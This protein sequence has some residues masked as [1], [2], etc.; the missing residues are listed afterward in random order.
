MAL[1]WKNYHSTTPLSGFNGYVK[2]ISLK[3][4]TQIETTSII[5]PSELN[6][7]QVEVKSNNSSNTFYNVTGITLTNY[8]N[9]FI[10]SENAIIQDGNGFYTGLQFNST[11]SIKS[12]TG[13]IN[14]IIST[15]NETH[16]Y[17]QCGPIVPHA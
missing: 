13:T 1:I 7:K 3:N 11:F 6:L 16:Y 4:N 9:I 10:K 5:L 8:S 15:D 17:Q 14:L 2:Q 12:S